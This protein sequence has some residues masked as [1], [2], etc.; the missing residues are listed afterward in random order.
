MKIAIGVWNVVRLRSQWMGW[1]ES[2]RSE[3]SEDLNMQ[4]NAERDVIL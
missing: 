1:V 3:G 2:S 4:M